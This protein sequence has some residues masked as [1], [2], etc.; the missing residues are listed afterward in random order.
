VDLGALEVELEAMRAAAAA[1]DEG[2]FMDHDER[3]HA[4]ILAASG[5]RRLVAA[6]AALRDAVRGR[7]ASTAGRSRSLEEIHAEHA[8]ILAA[9]QASDGDR[10]GAAMRYHLRRTGDLLA[11]QYGP[12]RA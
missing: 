9:L 10:A 6:V 1:G 2:A 11:A 3:F 7:G 8:A 4:L 12:T 5:N